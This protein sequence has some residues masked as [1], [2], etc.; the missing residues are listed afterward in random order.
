MPPIAG[1]FMY[2]DY[3]AATNFDAEGKVTEAKWNTTN[4][5]MSLFEISEKYVVKKFHHYRV[6]LTPEQIKVGDSFKK[7]KGSNMC[8]INSV[9]IECIR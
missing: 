1:Y 2:S 7:V 8:S 3:M 4:H 6:T 9:P 5:Q